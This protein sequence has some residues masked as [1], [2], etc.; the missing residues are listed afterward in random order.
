MMAKPGDLFGSVDNRWVFGRGGC[1][2]LP[3]T[4][5][6]AAGNAAG[7]SLKL[8]KL[9]LGSAGE[10]SAA[11]VRYAG[12]LAESAAAICGAEQC[13][14]WRARLRAGDPSVGYRPLAAGIGIVSGPAT[15]AFSVGSLSLAADAANAPW[16][17]SGWSV[18]ETRG[19]WTTAS[20]AELQ[21]ALNR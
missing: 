15:C 12:N 14:G 7:Q 17:V 11:V 19:V 1:S 2:K 18:R 9:T 8:L 16:L 6:A 10:I 4:C 21:I 13:A 5:A 20:S 3:A